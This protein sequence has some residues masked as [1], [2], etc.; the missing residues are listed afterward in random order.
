MASWSEWVNTQRARFSDRRSRA[1]DEPV[2]DLEGLRRALVGELD[3][4]RASTAA[5]LERL[6]AEI[7]TTRNAIW[8]SKAVTAGDRII[9]GCRHLN[10][11]F[12]IDPDDHLIGPRF[13]VDGEYEPATT[14]F[15]LEHIGSDDTC[16]DVGANFGY[17]SCLF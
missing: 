11:V 17:Y 12:Y 5:E 13:I 7:A 4:L 2:A 3:Q 8:S 15:V 16:I 14:A 6:R 10:L 9:V 1:V